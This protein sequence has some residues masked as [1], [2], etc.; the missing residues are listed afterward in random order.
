MPLTVIKINQAKPKEK[1]FK[2][3]D[4]KG[5]RQTNVCF[6]LRRWPSAYVLAYET[7]SGTY[8]RFGIRLDAQELDSFF[9]WNCGEMPRSQEKSES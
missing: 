5:P 2:I 9:P 1:L 6:N 8:E 4:E 7:L 3:L